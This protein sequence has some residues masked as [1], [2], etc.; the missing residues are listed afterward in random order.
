ELDPKDEHTLL[1]LAGFGGRSVRRLASSW[2]AALA[3]ARALPGDALPT[4]PPSDGPP[5]PHRW[6]ER[7]PAAAARLTRCRE[8]VTTLAGAHR[9]PPETLITPD[10]VRRLA[11]APPEELSV[12]SV[13]EALGAL[14]ARPW[15]VELVAPGLAK[16][17]EPE[18]PAPEA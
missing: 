11:W 8:V 4:T 13:V 1:T 17:L 14:G 15:Q 7:D 6:A 9:V 5:P 2:L 12:E 16:A 3:D 10:S 18:A